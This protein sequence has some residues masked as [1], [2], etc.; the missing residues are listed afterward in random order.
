MVRPEHFVFAI[1]HEGSPLVRQA[2]GEMEGVWTEL[3]NVCNVERA[4]LSLV[5][6]QDAR[7]PG[8]SPGQ[9]DVDEPEPQPKKHRSTTPLL[10]KLGRDL[11]ALAR[12]DKLTPCIGRRDEMRS[13]AQ[14]LRRQSKN[15]PV[16][17]GD[18]GVGKTS[19]SK[20][21]Q[22]IVNADVPEATAVAN[23]RG[24]HGE[25]HRGLYVSGAV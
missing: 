9:G 3:C 22:R 7:A 5:K 25:S 16:L 17:V 2:V 4:P 10:D 13:V 12:E 15:N 14:V 11:T 21:R 20:V 6:P 24:Q 23:R 18:P 8:D 19:S 1:L